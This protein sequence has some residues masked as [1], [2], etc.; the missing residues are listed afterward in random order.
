MGHH[1]PST[2]IAEY[3]RLHCAALRLRCHGLIHATTLAKTDMESSHFPRNAAMDLSFDEMGGTQR[4]DMK[5]S[6][7]RREAHRVA[8]E[9]MMPAV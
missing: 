9:L 7:R 6:P 1:Q 2:C 5:Q 8:L 4:R 3:K